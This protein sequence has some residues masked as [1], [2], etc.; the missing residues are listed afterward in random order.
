MNFKGLKKLFFVSLFSRRLPEK[1]FFKRKNGKKESKK[2]C[3]QQAKGNGISPA[4]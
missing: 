3:P 1:L 2:G 4:G